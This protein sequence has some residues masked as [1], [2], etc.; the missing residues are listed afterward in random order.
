MAV[1]MFHHALIAVPRGGNAS[2][3]KYTSDGH[4]GVQLRHVLHALKEERAV[5]RPLVLSLVRASVATI[6]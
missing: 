2:S 5:I 4:T 3:L 6:R 1:E